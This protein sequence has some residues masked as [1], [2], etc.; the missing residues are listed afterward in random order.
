M[1]CTLLWLLLMLTL[2]TEEFVG[3]FSDKL[4]AQLAREQ[5]IEDFTLPRVD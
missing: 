3:R 5:G 4:L 1:K 2:G